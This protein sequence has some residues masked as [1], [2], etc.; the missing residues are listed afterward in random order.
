MSE[1]NRKVWTWT[2]M[3]QFFT[4]LFHFEATLK[5][6]YRK[7]WGIAIFI[8]ENSSLLSKIIDFL[9]GKA[10]F[11]LKRATSKIRT[12]LLIRREKSFFPRGR[13]PKSTLI[14][15]INFTQLN[16]GSFMFEGNW[17]DKCL[18]WNLVAGPPSTL[19]SKTHGQGF[20]S[21][22]LSHHY[23]STTTSIGKTEHTSCP[24]TDGHSGNLAYHLLEIFSQLLIR[25]SLGPLRLLKNR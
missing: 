6:E 24:W 22:H 13:A 9:L 8:S 5:L 1:I 16:C 12:N 14:N 15:L 17:S 2:P 7:P 20:H 21:R 19:V 10:T 4:K 3:T 11:N 23:L 25:S 18:I